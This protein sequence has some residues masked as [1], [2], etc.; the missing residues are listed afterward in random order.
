MKAL[1]PVKYLGEIFHVVCEAWIEG[2]E[3]VVFLS[4]GM[5][6]EHLRQSGGP[7]SLQYRCEAALARECEHPEYSLSL[8]TLLD[9]DEPGLL[10]PDPAQ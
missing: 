10:R 1:A 2:H 5:F 6:P 8:D 3:V 9:L 4:R 7:G